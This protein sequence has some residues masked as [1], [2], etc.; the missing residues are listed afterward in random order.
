MATV[1]IAASDSPFGV[2]GFNM[3][4]VNGGVTIPNPTQTPA[5]VILLVTRMGGTLGST[6]ISWNVTGPGSN[7]VPSSDIAASTIRGT[8]T[9]TDGQRYVS[10]ADFYVCNAIFVPAVLVQ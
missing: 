9:L 1:F 3:D 6:D 10:Y 2:V 7:G 4:V 8:L 5:I